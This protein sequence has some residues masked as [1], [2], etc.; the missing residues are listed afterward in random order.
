METVEVRDFQKTAEFYRKTQS[1]EP[2]WLR[3]FREAVGAHRAFIWGRG[4]RQPHIKGSG[5]RPS[6]PPYPTL[7]PANFMSNAYRPGFT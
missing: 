1:L 6:I 4:E 5:Q 3:D 7:L 2:A